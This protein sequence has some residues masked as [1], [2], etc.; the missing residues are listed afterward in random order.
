LEGFGVMVDNIGH[1][2]IVTATL[3]APVSPDLS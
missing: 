1:R 2:F 3:V